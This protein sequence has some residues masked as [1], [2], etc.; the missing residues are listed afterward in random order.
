MLKF[1]QL[2]LICAVSGCVAPRTPQLAEVARTSD[3][4]AV[5]I[6]GGQWF[7]GAQ[8]RER[9]VYMELGVFI[10]RPSREPDSTI[11][12]G[13]AY[14][15][16]PF[17]EAHNHNFDA[18]SPAAAKVLVNKYL[19]D[20]IFYGENPANVLRARKGLEGFIN[21]PT[22]I[23]VTFSNAA[24]TGPG[25]HPIGLFLRNLGRGVM[26]PT[27]TNTTGGFM[28]IIHDQNDLERKWPAILAS[29]PDFI[30][31]IL[32][33]SDQYEQRLADSTTF[34][35]RGFDPKLLPWVV[36]HARD[37]GLRVMTHVESAADFHNALI[38]GV[39]II[40]HT[41]GFR[42]NEQTQW[43]DFTPYLISDADAA[44]AAR[45]GTYVVTTLAGIVGVPD[46]ALRHRADSLFTINLRT[47]KRH[48]VRIILGSDS[49]RET[50][51]PEAMYLS[52]LGV[53]SNAELLRA[54]SEVTPR[55][56][57]PNRRIGKLSPGYEASFIALDANP[58]AD[59]RN[60]TKIRLRV[61]QG[62]TLQL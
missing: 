13:G 9:T 16:P 57:F 2:L 25:G 39:Q 7:D 53:F 32:A 40:G 62:Y 12:L 60:V 28:W 6:T 56:I 41:P 26:L 18:S 43:P 34:N 59:F 14:V 31:V 52:S 35:W 33:Y 49:F 36:S 47:L 15:V 44:L 22:G 55:A 58:L 30:K 19:K 29:K 46:T 50:D 45:Q 48:N 20:G 10:E 54:W 8:F 24:L 51:L 3:A 17:A 61:K 37:A 27:D 11:D 42:G 23:D 1:Q 21:I 5:K 38:A 4:P